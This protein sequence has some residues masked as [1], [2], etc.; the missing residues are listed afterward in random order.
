MQ[1]LD[2][3]IICLIIAYVAMKLSDYTKSA[4]ELKITLGAPDKIQAT[5]QDYQD[6]IKH[7]EGQIYILQEKLT[8]IGSGSLTH[9]AKHGI[10]VINRQIKKLNKTLKEYQSAL[11]N[12]E[13]ISA[14]ELPE[15]KRTKI[16]KSYLND[17]K[18]L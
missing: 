17:K 3:I 5:K 9:E 13:T 14:S 4:R 15:D 8:D 11:T 16:L 7:I 18:R 12:F 2:V 1:S 10:K 6:H